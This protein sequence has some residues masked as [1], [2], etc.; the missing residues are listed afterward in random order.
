MKSPL[1][2]LCSAALLSTAALAA[3]DT[4]PT[5]AKSDSFTA[6]DSDGDGKVSK[7]EA[8]GHEDIVNAFDKLDRDR[9]G[10]VSKREF[11]RN[12]MPK[13]KPSY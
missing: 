11:R 12:T 5:N 3:E 10:F 9:D 13:P 1:V 6:L 8:A 7:D 4:Q 2:L